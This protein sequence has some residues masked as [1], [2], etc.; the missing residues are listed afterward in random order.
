[1]EYLG[2]SAGIYTLL[3]RLGTDPNLAS[4]P[5]GRLADHVGDMY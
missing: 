5:C 2:A 1:M 3:G 4:G